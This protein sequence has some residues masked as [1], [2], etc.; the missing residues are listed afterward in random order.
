M[1]DTDL[2]VHVS[3]LLAEAG[4]ELSRDRTDSLPEEMVF[5]KLVADGDGVSFK[6][7]VKYLLSSDS[8][9]SNKSWICSTEFILPT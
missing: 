7:R 1:L 6:L 9:R 8:F 4:S 5:V 3:L 2:T